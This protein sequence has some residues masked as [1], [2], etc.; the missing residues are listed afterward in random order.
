MRKAVCLILCFAVLM[1]AVPFAYS[2]ESGFNRNLSLDEINFLEGV[3][4]LEKADVFSSNTD[5]T[6]T[7]GEAARLLIRMW[8]TLRTILQ[9]PIPYLRIRT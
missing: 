8:A 9:A 6:V 5:F 2:A 1:S 3:G 7:K 4:I